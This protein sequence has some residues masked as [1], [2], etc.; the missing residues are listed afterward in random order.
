[1]RV[2]WLLR[3]TSCR[4]SPAFILQ[5]LLGNAAPILQTAMRTVS[6]DSAPAKIERGRIIMT[7]FLAASINGTR[8]CPP[9]FALRNS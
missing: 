3:M 1:M 9:M 7:A 4:I 2:K 5:S 8:V 6:D